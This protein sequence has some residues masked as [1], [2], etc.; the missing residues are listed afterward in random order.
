MFCFKFRVALCLALGLCHFASFA[1]ANEANPGLAGAA[2]RF[3][4]AER[5]LRAETTH[6]EREKLIKQAIALA[7]TDIKSVEGEEVLLWILSSPHSSPNVVRAAQL[8][9]THHTTSKDSLR[10]LL[11]FSQRPRES[12]PS[13]F[14]SFK[15]ANAST[16][17]L[18]L[19]EFCDANHTRS[20]LLISDEMKLNPQR[21][22]K[23]KSSLGEALAQQLLKADS[24]TLEKAA[25]QQGSRLQM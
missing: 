21:I 10:A 7:E 20:L 8:L 18:W 15:T 24:A 17:H 5:A 6:V 22:N 14:S 3:K 4:I 1:Q 23:W 12:T 2:K 19:V 16:D 25:G 13:L 9:A 11:R